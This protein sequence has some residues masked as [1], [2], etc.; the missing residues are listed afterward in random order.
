MAAVGVALAE[1]RPAWIDAFAATAQVERPGLHSA[2]AFLLA[3]HD[4]G[5]FGDGFQRQRLDVARQLG[6]EPSARANNPR[7]DTLGYLLWS[8]LADPK[9]ERHVPAVRLNIVDADGTTPGERLT[10]KALRPWMAAVAG[11]HGRPPEHG[12]HTEAILGD[13][14]GLKRPD[15]AWVDAL[16]FVNEARAILQPAVVSRCR[17]A[18]PIDESVW[19]TSSWWL[20]GYA[21]LCDWVG[22]NTEWFPFQS[23]TGN[24]RGYWSI[25]LERAGRAVQGA[26]LGSPCVR[27]FGGFR[28]LFAEIA[29][30]SPLQVQV[31]T[32]QFGDGPQL[33][34]LEDLTGSGKTEA[35]LA[36]V[37]R[38]FDS[39]KADGFYFALPT[40]A[41]SNAMFS[42][43]EPVIDRLFEAKPPPSFLIA[44]SG[45][46]LC[47][48]AAGIG[49]ETLER[50]PG[51]TYGADETTASELAR[52]WLG[53]SRKKSL[54]ADAGVGTID[55]ALMGALQAKHNSLRLLG[56][57]RHVLVVDEVHACDEYMN[58]IL[59]E[60]LRVQAAG[61]GSAVLLSATLPID[62]RR[63]L[64]EAFREGLG[65]QESAIEGEAYPALVRADRAGVEVVPVAARKE[66]ERVV[67]V[68]F[69][70]T[71]D[72]VVR[73]CRDQAKAG[74]CVA[75]IRNTV[76][77][78]LEAF[79]RLA[80]ELGPGR[81]QLF[82]A[83][84]PMG[85]R[86]EIEQ[87]VV[88]RFGP[89]SFATE[90]EG[91]IVVSTQVLE[92]SLDLDFDEMVSD[93][94]P[95]DRLIQRAGRLHRHHRGRPGN[96]T[97]HV[98]APAWNEQPPTSW[99][100]D[101]FNG[102]V[103]VYGRPS[104]LWRT[105]RI[106][107]SEERLDLPA[108]A[109][110]LIE[111]VYGADDSS[112]PDSLL[113]ERRELNSQGKELRDGA[114]AQHNKIRLDHGYVRTGTSW[115]DDEFVPTRLGDPTVT[116]R[117]VRAGAGVIGPW[118]AAADVSPGVRWRL[119][120][121]SVRTTLTRS[122]RPDEEVALRAKLAELGAEPPAH[123]VPIEMR[124]VG[125]E[126][127]G[128]GIAARGADR[129]APVTIVFTP[130][131]GLDFRSEK[132][133]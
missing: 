26:G 79:D 18:T 33:L 10:K 48:R 70:E 7:H 116:L 121:V 75:W 95:I 90:R 4:L 12:G 85:D 66:S 47:G 104:L 74:K 122:G 6:R 65:A 91:R 84:F 101:A 22:S 105:Q 21:T 92:Q 5:K 111:A 14:F 61:G 93:L 97:L 20:A 89:A 53:D 83:R 81:V 73:W 115:A 58:G 31:S 114:M 88:R 98:L 25:A 42:R 3:L 13:H 62:T 56:L 71:F 43:V 32:V 36:L 55:Q 44:H 57:H 132:G 103:A 40:M 87:D 106:L 76:R 109:R 2:I 1:A 128:H 17:T 54:L 24:L 23:K 30:P 45:P 100:G 60:L 41:T 94:A 125:E 34:L 50:R 29:E 39:G 82:H 15:G 78:A 49:A 117:L 59:M 38:L 35:A 130:G 9:G 86:L 120:E 102:S 107:Q 28:T 96:P 108:R 67:K 68:E 126:W 133:S 51:S 123:V 77:D 69:L 99:P 131:R 11:H 16:A 8:E 110:L 113:I 127:H 37:G 80:A 46:K 72:E 129:Q 64:V 124:A 27:S 118:S 112:V 119:G 63:K 52:S 19:K